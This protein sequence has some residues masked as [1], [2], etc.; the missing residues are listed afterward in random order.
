[1]SLPTPPT[2]TS[3]GQHPAVK[4]DSAPPTRSKVTGALAAGACAACCALP[5]L[6]AA[7]VLTGAGAVIAERTLLAVTAGLVALA[8]GMWW[9]HRRRSAHRAA[10]LVPPTSVGRGSGRAERWPASCGDEPP[11]FQ[12]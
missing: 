6:V 3:P 11:D 2:A 1:M 4:V 5:L 12:Q 8:L 10:G 9:L 7:G